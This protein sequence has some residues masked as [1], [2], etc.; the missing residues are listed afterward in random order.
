MIAKTYSI[1][2]FGF[3]GLTIEIEGDSSNGLPAFNIVGMATKTVFEARERVKAAIKSSGFSFPDK[4]LTINLAPADQEKS[5]THLDVAIA[6]NILILSGQ[7]AQTDVEDA[8]FIG[9][10]SLD[11]TIRPVSGIVS[12]AEAAKA[13]GRKKLFVPIGNLAQASLISGIEIFG[14]T[15]LSELFL[16]LKDE[17]CLLSV[18]QFM[19]NVVKNTKTD[20]DEGISFAQIYG[21][22]L[23]KRALSIAVAGH[24]NILLS[25]PPGTGKTALA[26]AALSLLPPLNSAEQIAITKLYSLIDANSDIITHRP[27]RSPHHTSSLPAL[28]GGG[29]KAS[30]GDISLAHLGVLFLDELPEYPRQILEALRQPLEDRQISISRAKC[31]ISYPADFMLIA[32]MNPCPC[33]YLGD[34]HHTCTCSEVQIQNYRKKLSGPFLDRIDLCVDVNRIKTSKLL[35]SSLSTPSTDLRA[36]VSSAISIQHDRYANHPTIYNASL[37]SNQITQ[38][39]KLDSEAK[40]FLDAA[41]DSLNLSARSYFKTIK[42]ARTIADLES[43]TNISKKHLAEALTFRKKPLEKN[44]SF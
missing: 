10:L 3:G 28:V 39:I 11:G 35:D 13:A 44:L 20:T 6:L 29:P 5:G 34:P 38:Y 8:V 12:I 42:V 7:L 40:A 43:A 27:F 17:Q 26:K 1:I 16:H 2:P 21:Q 23:A 18:A 41:A 31:H 32:T 19:K 15:N 14:L 36:A 30:P 22:S 24:H 37:S 33:G 25:G 9:E 4:K